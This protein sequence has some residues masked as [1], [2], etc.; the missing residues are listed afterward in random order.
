MAGNNNSK[1]LDVVTL[2]LE[3]H[4]KAVTKADNVQHLT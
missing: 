4:R 1:S 2:L 3:A